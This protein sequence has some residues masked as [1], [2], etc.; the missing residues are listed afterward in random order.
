MTT[1][2]ITLKVQLRAD[3]PAEVVEDIRFNLKHDAEIL[4]SEHVD[5]KISV[6]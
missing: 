3:T 4:L 5:A 6:K 1:K 2:Q